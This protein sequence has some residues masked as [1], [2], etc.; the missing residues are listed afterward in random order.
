MIPQSTSRLLAI[1]VLF[2]VLA[3]AYVGASGIAELYLAQGKQIAE[4]RAMLGQFRAAAADRADLE[5]QKSE[6]GRLEQDKSYYMVAPS[7]SVAAAQLQ[8]TVKS[9]IE[10]SGGA[11]QS[12]QIKSTRQDDAFRRIGV[13]VQMTAT[14]EQLRQVLEQLQ[15]GQPL[16]FVES[17]DLR[18]RQN[19]R[20]QGKSG[21]TEDRVLDLRLDIYG[22]MRA[23]T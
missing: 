14:I 3:A 15:S 1:G 17:L 9:A 4:T 8:L 12:T 11:L 22:L 2:M 13:R 23:S 19:P 10:R 20:A 18:T 21:V 5:R 6:L 16:L 7:D